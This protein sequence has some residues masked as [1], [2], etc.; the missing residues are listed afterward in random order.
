MEA[1]SKIVTTQQTS[2][3]HKIAMLVALAF[4]CLGLVSCVAKA[5]PAAS[6]LFW[7]LGFAAYAYARAGAWWTNG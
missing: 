4:I 7:V 2:K 1:D 5:Q 3:K 6:G